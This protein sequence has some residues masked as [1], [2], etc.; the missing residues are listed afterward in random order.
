MERSERSKNASSKEFGHYAERDLPCLAAQDLPTFPAFYHVD[1]FLGFLLKPLTWRNELPDR[2]ETARQFIYNCSTKPQPEL[3]G[4]CGANTCGVH[5]RLRYCMLCVQ[6]FPIVVKYHA[7]K[8]KCTF[9]KCGAAVL[10]KRRLPPLANDLFSHKLR[11]CLVTS[12][13]TQPP[14][15]KMR[16]SVSSFSN[17]SSS[18]R[19]SD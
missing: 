1:F 16:W 9:S 18:L 13:G 11:A 15:K 4:L 2:I 6:I 7:R 8:R 3:R 5:V 19:A 17:T 14:S 10:F 12:C